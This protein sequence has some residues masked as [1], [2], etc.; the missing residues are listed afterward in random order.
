MHEILKNWNP[1]PLIRMP[2][3]SHLAQ[4]EGATVGGEPTRVETTYDS[5]PT[6]GVKC[7]GRGGTLCTYGTS[8]SVLYELLNPLILSDKSRSHDRFW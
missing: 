8:L 5:T 2:L 1:F 4:Q 7:E 3:A 6:E